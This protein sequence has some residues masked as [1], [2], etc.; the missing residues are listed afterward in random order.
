MEYPHEGLEVVAALPGE[1]ALRD[2]E[3]PILRPTNSVPAWSKDFHTMAWP[4]DDTGGI[5]IDGWN[6]STKR[7]QFSVQAMGEE[8]PI[9][10][11]SCRASGGAG[12]T[13][14]QC[15]SIAL[16]A[17]DG[18]P[19]LVSWTD[20]HAGVAL[21][22]ARMRIDGREAVLVRYATKIDILHGLLV[23]EGGRWVPLIRQP[24]YA[25]VC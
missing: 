3:M 9:D 23:R 6:A 10:E 19:L 25:N 18:V 8:Q 17:A 7:L 4:T 2:P 16:I 5:R 14:I 11:P 15:Q 1:P 24:D 21:P 20:Y 12:L 22:I 13:Q